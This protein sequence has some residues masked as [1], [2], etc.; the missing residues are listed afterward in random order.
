MKSFVIRSW[1]WILIPFAVIAFVVFMAYKQHRAADNYES[2]RQSW[3]A[4]LP[5]TAP[6][7]QASCADKGPNRD[8]YLSWGYK[9]V[10]WPDGITVWAIIATGFVIGWQ[11]WETRKA[12]KAQIDGNRAWI[13]ADLEKMEGRG[14]TNG[15]GYTREEELSLTTYLMFRLNLRNQGLSPA[16]IESIQA[17]MEILPR[18]QSPPKQVEFVSFP[19]HPSIM[20]GGKDVINPDLECPG[21]MNKETDDLFIWVVIKYHDGHGI[22]GETSVGYGMSPSGMLFKQSN[23]PTRNYNK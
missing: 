7:K 13:F 5:S 2:D 16:W 15:S 23:I 1:A 8:S 22:Q 14:Y 12:A 18:K 20:A 21:H 11:S 4:T 10:A 17:H 6:E 19:Y 9:L 3:C